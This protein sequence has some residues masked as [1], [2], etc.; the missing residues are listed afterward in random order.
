MVVSRFGSVSRVGARPLLW[1]P[2]SDLLNGTA[3]GETVTNH[4]VLRDA[5]SKQL[6]HHADI[7]TVVTDGM[8]A[9][10]AISQP[11]PEWH[12]MR[13]CYSGDGWQVNQWNPEFGEKSSSNDDWVISHAEMIRENGQYGTL[14]FSGVSSTGTLLQPPMMG[15]QSLFGN[16]LKDRRGLERRMMMLQ[17]WTES[18]NPLSEKQL[19]TLVRL[20]DTF[21][22]RTLSRLTGS[23]GQRQARTLGPRRKE[24]LR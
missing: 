6:G 4:R 18:S 17:L 20:F 11:Y 1:E 16:R 19:E 13:L 7:W 15:L 22:V 21:R 23:E 5:N 9:R 24:A 12:D 14:L 8:V 10:V 3:I 2:S